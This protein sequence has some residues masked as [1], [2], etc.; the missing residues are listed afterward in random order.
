MLSR[1]RSLSSVFTVFQQQNTED[2][3]ILVKDF[4]KAVMLKRQE[5]ER[6]SRRLDEKRRQ[7]EQYKCVTNMQENQ[8]V[9][10]SFECHESPEARNKREVREFMEQRA[11]KRRDYQAKKAE[12]AE[13]M[14]QRAQA[15]R[16]YL[17][18]KARRCMISTF[19]AELQ[20]ER[21][22]VE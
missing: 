17:A 11:Q 3:E 9:E 5:F 15:R 1:I 10:H 14:A 18:N 8:K 12:L 4:E 7:A 16:E 20:A 6:A 13:F 19:D 22:E 2:E 21:P